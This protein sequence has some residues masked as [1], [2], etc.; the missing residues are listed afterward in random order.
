MSDLDETDEYLFLFPFV[1]L[2]R[3]RS[4]RGGDACL[5]RLSPVQCTPVPKVAFC[6]HVRVCV[7]VRVCARLCSSS[8]TAFLDYNVLRNGSAVNREGSVRKTP[9]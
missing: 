7:C 9:L 1:V 2:F 8:P 3:H 6:L 4:K 5:M